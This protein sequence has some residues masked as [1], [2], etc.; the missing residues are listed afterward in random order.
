MDFKRKHHS[1]RNMNSGHVPTLFDGILV[2]A[3]TAVA[4]VWAIAT[5]PGVVGLTAVLA[6]VATVV[7]V[8]LMIATTAWE[9]V[10]ATKWLSVRYDAMIRAILRNR[11]DILP[12]K[13]RADHTEG[14]R[15]LERHLG[16]VFLL[17]LVFLAYFSVML[18]FFYG[19]GGQPLADPSR[20]LVAAFLGT[21]ALHLSGGGEVGRALP[22]VLDFLVPFGIIVGL[23]DLTVIGPY[24]LLSWALKYAP[25]LLVFFAAYYGLEVILVRQSN[26][27]DR[28]EHIERAPRD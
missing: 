2:V 15:G 13:W 5:S 17:F 25:I 1:E 24:T 20:L 28:Q 14:I 26:G 9:L 11:R 22:V 3:I 7:I 6:L 21:S 18:V 23:I 19:L 16:S 10:T 12:A 8:V 4:V 27:T